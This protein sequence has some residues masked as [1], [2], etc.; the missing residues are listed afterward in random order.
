MSLSEEEF[1][2][3]NSHLIGFLQ[4]SFLLIAVLL[5]HARWFTPVILALWEVGGGQIT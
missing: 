2:V 3:L 1:A 5:D 4:W